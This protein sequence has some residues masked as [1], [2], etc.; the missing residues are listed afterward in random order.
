MLITTRTLSRNVPI[1]VAVLVLHAL[2]LWALKIGLL[3]RPTEVVVPVEVISE[4]V[5][6]PR[7][8][9]PPPPVAVR[10]LP[11]PRT[12][13]TE[14]PPPRPQAAP[15]M[16]LVAPV[17]PEP[18]PQAP[19]AAAAVTPPST[20]PAVA[21]AAPPAAVGGTGN[22]VAM[23]PAPAETRPPAPPRVELPSSDAEY[24]QNPRPV[25]P[26][27]SRRLREQGTV[28]VHVQIGVDGRAQKAEI[29]Q[30]SGFDRLDQAA[31]ATVLNWR[32][33][34]GRLGGKPEAM[35]HTVPIAWVLK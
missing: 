15:P 8:A 27:M 35:W 3:Q 19:T 12:T 28:L 11:P 30:S 33:V 18:S 23:A 14:A 21:V 10:E 34:P 26:P 4:A 29:Q 1:V 22:N 17:N 2:A 9:P 7:P 16:P 25:Y 24:L 6:P 31:L 13:R 20:L 32:Y 5:T